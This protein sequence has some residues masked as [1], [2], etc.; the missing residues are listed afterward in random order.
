MGRRWNWPWNWQRKLRVSF[1]TADGG[2][3]RELLGDHT[4]SVTCVMSSLAQLADLTGDAA[5]LLRVKA[6]YDNG[7][8]A[9]RDPLGWVVE[10]SHPDAPPDRGEVNNTGDIVETA[11]ILGRWGWT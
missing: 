1:F 2:H 3:D 11:L 6:F 7:L 8:W 10:S 4:H 5:L 9:M